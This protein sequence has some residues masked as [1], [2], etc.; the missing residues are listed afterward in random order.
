MPSSPGKAPRAPPCGPSK[1]KRALRTA[2]CATHFGG[3]AGL[4]LALVDD[5]IADDHGRLPEDPAAMMTRMLGPDRDRTIAR[6]ELF[7]LATRNETLRARVVG[8]R[9]ELVALAREAGVHAAAA[10]G[11]VAA[12]DGFILDGLLR[13]DSGPDISTL[14]SRGR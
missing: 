12:V 5:L 9:D 6:Y 3:R 13:A 10:R 4:I 11:L 8:A 7:L 2:R 14:T 1:G